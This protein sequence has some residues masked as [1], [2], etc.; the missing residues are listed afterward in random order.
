MQ[1]WV[2]QVN[3]AA[4]EQKLWR[5]RYRSGAVRLKVSTL[6]ASCNVSP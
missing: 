1:A 3:P 6:S 4:A 5:Q 2:N